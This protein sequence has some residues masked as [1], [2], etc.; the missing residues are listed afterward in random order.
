MTQAPDFG[1]WLAICNLKA[2]YC[3]L[4]D[5]KD[6]DGWSDLFTEGCEIDTRSGGGTL[7]S[8][9]QAFVSMVRQSLAEAKTAHHV[10]SPEIAI[11][12]DVAQVIWAM[13][14]RVVKSTFTL[15]GYGHYHETC[16]RTAQGWKISKQTLSRLMVNLVDLTGSPV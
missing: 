2:R 12:G 8:G 14:N 15:T 3:R 1:D 13:Q 16:V 10:H 5:S 7:E 11:E 9:R 4:R 6:W